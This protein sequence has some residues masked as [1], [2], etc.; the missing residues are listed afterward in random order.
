MCLATLTAKARDPVTVDPKLFKVEFENDQLRVLRY[1][2]GP[3]EASA[4]YEHPGSVGGFVTD[5]DTKFTLPDG[6]R[7]EKREKATARLETCSG[8]QQRNML[9]K[10]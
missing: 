1:K 3:H 4:M 7:T 10:V 5:G 6:K 9:P 8:H 2:A